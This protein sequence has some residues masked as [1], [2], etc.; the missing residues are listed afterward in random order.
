MSKSRNLSVFSDW[1]HAKDY[2]KAMWMILQHSEADDFVCS[3]GKSN[4]VRELVDYVFDS[5]KLDKDKFLSVNPKYFRP[6]ELDVLKGDCSKLKSVL[7][8]KPEYS[9]ESMLDDM[10]EKCMVKYSE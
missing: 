10:I 4:T 7:G 8:W 2:V 5:L 1:G 3:T 6:E 9:F